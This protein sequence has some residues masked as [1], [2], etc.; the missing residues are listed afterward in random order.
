MYGERILTVLGNRATRP[1]TDFI[2]RYIAVTADMTSAVWNTVAAHEIATVTGAVEILILPECTG[3]L[4]GA[5]ATLTLGD[6]TTADSIIAS[7]AAPSL[8]IGE[9]WADATMT[10][11][12]LT[13]TLMN[14]LDIVVVGKDIGY[15]IGT[16]ALTSGSILFHMFWSPISSDGLVV[17]GAG[18]AL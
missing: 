9:W 11:T 16:A 10:R 7:S 18:G 5:T 13:R 15:T 17:A 4:V 1:I 8:A 6:E 3:T 12:I 14:G 2:S